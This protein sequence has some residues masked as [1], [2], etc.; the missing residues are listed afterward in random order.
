MAVLRRVLA[1]LDNSEEQVEDV[2]NISPSQLRNV[3][4]RN[5]NTNQQKNCLK[6]IC[7]L[8]PAADQ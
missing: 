1:A 6:K 2:L 5:I 7:H 8:S 4:T 3:L